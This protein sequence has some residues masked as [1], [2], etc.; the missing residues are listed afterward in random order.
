VR[1][2]V[3]NILHRVDMEAAE[4][5]CNVGKLDLENRG[6]LIPRVHRISCLIPMGKKSFSPGPLNASSP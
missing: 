4:Q 3:A 6:G 2:D 1:D 5:R